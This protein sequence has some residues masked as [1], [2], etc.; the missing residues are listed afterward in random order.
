MHELG[1]IIEIVKQVELVAK[2]NEVD[3]IEAL[4]LQIGELSSMIPHYMKKLYPAAVEGTLL[5][6]STL[7]IEVIPGNGLCRE[8]G[9]VFNLMKE[10]GAC[11]GCRSKSFE[12][13]S[14]K[15]FMIKEIVC[16]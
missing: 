5:E 10:N 2:E 1:V 16:S 7:E 9:Q 15:E 6:N 8:C 14:G 11:P 12:L 13:L 4:V 3:K